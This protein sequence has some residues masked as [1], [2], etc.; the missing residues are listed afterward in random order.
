MPRFLLVQ[1]NYVLESFICIYQHC[2]FTCY[3]KLQLLS[4]VINSTVVETDQG[5]FII[6]NN[7]YF[8]LKFW[9]EVLFSD[10]FLFFS[11]MDCKSSNNANKKLI[12]GKDNANLQF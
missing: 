10:V 5:Q 3:K 8:E 2:V 4:Q 11:G 6:P 12:Q 9:C 1:V 7:E